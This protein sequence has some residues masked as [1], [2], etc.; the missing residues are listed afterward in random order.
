MKKV[1]FF[2]NLL[3]LSVLLNAQTYRMGEVFDPAEIEQVPR[4]VEL[5][6]RDYGALPSSYSLR[7][8]CP[9]PGDQG[10]YGTCPSWST[11]FYART[12]CEARDNGWTD[13]QKITSET[14]SPTFVYTLIKDFDDYNCQNGSS[15]K[16]ALETIWLKGVPKLSNLPYHCQSTIASLL[17]SQ[18][19]KYKTERPTMLFNQQQTDAN[20]RIRAVKKALAEDN[21]VL[22]SF[23]CYRSFKSVRSDLWNGDAS[24]NY[25]G[26]SMC[27]VSYDDNKYGGA[28]EVI[29]SW[30]VTWGNNGFCWIRYSD[31]CRYT[32]Y[33]M[34]MIVR[35]NTS[36][37]NNRHHLSGSLRLQLSTGEEMRGTLSNGIYKI[38]GEYISGTRY[39]I[40]ISNNQPAYVYVIGSDLQN[41]VSKVFPPNDK[42]SPALTYKSNNIAIP[43]EKWFVEM[44]NTTG[45]DYL[46]VLY[47]AQELDI[48]AIVSKIRNGNGS[49]YN[50]V[51]SALGGKIAPSGEI[52]FSQSGISFSA[53]TTKTVVPVIAEI[54]HR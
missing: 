42:I 37:V 41:N 54:V 21:P 19:E 23:K 18:A 4:Q 5:L 34:Q 24:G 50:R 48:N 22:I 10:D 15:T 33:A 17:Y 38:S 27:V 39:R 29:N 45:K 32:N 6:T 14:F 52:N 8:W 2:S 49:F 11:A 31:F 25:G 36:V 28:F 43:D 7:K 16:K 40:Y 13:R 47:S 3:L 30:G 12:I 51:S 1:I 46:C 53:Q 9:Y 35:K 20:L 26:H 44:D